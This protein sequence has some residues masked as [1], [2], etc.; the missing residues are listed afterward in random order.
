MFAIYSVCVTSACFVLLQWASWAAVGESKEQGWIRSVPWEAYELRPH[1]LPP[2]LPFFPSV[3]KKSK[4]V[5]Q[6]PSIPTIL[7]RLFA[8]SV[9]VLDPLSAFSVA[10]N[11]LQIVETSLRVLDKTAECYKN[12]APDGIS[13]ILDNVCTIEDLN[14]DLRDFLPGNL[15]KTPLSPAELRLAEA[16]EQCLRLSGDFIDLLDS[17]KVTKKSVWHSIGISI[18]TMWNQDKVA[19]FEKSIS[20]SRANLTLAFLLLMQ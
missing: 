4:E 16:N 1:D 9:M 2:P 10:C 18:K 19:S 3:K 6:Y 20:D 17:L 11:V 7:S 8:L 12:G 14:N 15:E 13:T 5:R